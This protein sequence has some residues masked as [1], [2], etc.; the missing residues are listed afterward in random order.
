MT[1]L[2]PQQRINQQRRQKASR[3]NI[4]RLFALGLPTVV[5]TTAANYGAIYGTIQ[6]LTLIPPALHWVVAV[7]GLVM[8]IPLNIAVISIGVALGMILF[9]LLGGV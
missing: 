3:D 9:A 4:I 1:N 5:L 7:F 6:A 2:T 8:L